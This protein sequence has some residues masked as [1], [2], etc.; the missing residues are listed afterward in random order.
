MR[1]APN[2][3]R[4]VEIDHNSAWR[5]GVYRFGESFAGADWVEEDY[6]YSTADLRARGY[7][8]TGLDG[9]VLIT[10]DDEL[11]LDED[12]TAMIWG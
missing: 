12:G 7:W 6:P 9:R 3:P 10:E 8:E 1:L 4:V 2:S 11:M 5:D